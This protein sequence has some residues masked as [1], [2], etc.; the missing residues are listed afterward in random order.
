MV[1]PDNSQQLM[2]TSPYKIRDKKYLSIVRGK[3]CLICKKEGEA[4]HVMYAEPRGAG[5]KVGDNWVVPICHEHY[6]DI[7]HYGNDGYFKVLTP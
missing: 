6:M 4:H 1:C 2:M 7:H 5:L 3:P